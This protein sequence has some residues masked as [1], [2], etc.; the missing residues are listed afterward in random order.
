M[1]IPWLHFIHFNQ[2]YNQNR[3]QCLHILKLLQVM[4][5]F[6]NA[7]TFVLLHFNTLQFHTS[8]QSLGLLR[9]LR[10]ESTR[11]NQRLLLL[12]LVLQI[13]GIDEDHLLLGASGDNSRGCTHSKDIGGL[14]SR[15]RQEIQKW[16][17]IKQDQGTW[18]CEPPWRKQGRRSS[19]H[20]PEKKWQF[21]VCRYPHSCSRRCRSPVSGGYSTHQGLCAW[22]KALDFTC[23]LR[24]DRTQRY[25][26]HFLPEGW[27][28]WVDRDS[29]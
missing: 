3:I 28:D 18:S 1:H 11:E 21:A 16:R 4:V 17:Q 12:L 26:C 9:N 27:M 15:K 24:G 22:D 19:P 25:P 10:E 20:H 29:W 23:R 5:P 13:N 7:S 6:V 14:I 2:Q 8:T